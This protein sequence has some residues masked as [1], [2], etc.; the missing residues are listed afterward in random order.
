MRGQLESKSNESEVSLNDFE[1]W[2]EK[3]GVEKCI[4]CEMGWD[5]DE[6]S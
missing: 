6:G 3:E 1:E 4:R 5:D 2:L